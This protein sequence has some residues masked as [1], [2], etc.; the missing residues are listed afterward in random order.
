MI[1]DVARALCHAA[2]S[3]VNKVACVMCDKDGNCTF[4]Q[5]FIREAEFAVQ[6]VRKH[7]ILTMKKRK[8]S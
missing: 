2:G 7:A 6:A 1:D 3:D 8:R 4:W 5:S